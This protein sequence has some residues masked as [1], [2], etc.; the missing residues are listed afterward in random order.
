MCSFQLTW[1]FLQRSGFSLVTEAS[2]PQTFVKTEPI[3]PKADDHNF[4]YAS[5]TAESSGRNPGHI[6]ELSY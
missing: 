3:S 4:T 6:V 1:F 2:S 5:D